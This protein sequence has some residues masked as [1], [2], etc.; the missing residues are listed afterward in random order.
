LAARTQAD[1]EY[2]AR[3]LAGVRLA[4]ADLVTMED[5]REHM[6]RISDALDKLTAEKTEQSQNPLPGA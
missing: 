3:E 4:L 6:E 1:T 2:L 5:L